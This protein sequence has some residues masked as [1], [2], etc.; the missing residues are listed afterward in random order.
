MARSQ[1]PAVRYRHFDGLR[2][3]YDDDAFD[4]T[5]TVCVMH[6]VRPEQW[7]GFAAEKG[8]PT[9]VREFFY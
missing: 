4:L 6:H 3:P 5:F 1:F 2:L 9:E 7:P 8:T